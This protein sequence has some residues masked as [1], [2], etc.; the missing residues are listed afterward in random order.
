MKKFFCITCD[1]YGKFEKCKISYLLE[2]A[3]VLSINCGKCK[4]GDYKTFKEEE[5]IEILNYLI[6]TK[7]YK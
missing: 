4:N 3:L 7:K 1:K 6:D 5:S 2:N